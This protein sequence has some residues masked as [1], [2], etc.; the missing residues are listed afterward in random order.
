MPTALW[1]AHVHVTDAE[2]YDT[3]AGLILAKLGRFPEQGEKVEWEAYD[4][5][6][7]EVSATSIIKVRIVSR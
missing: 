5:H 2:A 3:I 6:C 4:L 1:I 7:E